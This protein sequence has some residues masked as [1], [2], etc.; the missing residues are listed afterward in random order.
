M[1]IYKGSCHCGKVRFKIEAEIDHVRSCDCSICVKRGALNYR[2]PK[3][4]LDL[5][6]PWDDLILY[7][8]GDK[9]AKD[10][11]CSTCG[12][13]PFRRPSNPTDKELLEGV[14]PFDGWAINARCLEGID[15]ELL[16]V[17]E[18]YGSKI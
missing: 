10:F 9:T 5:F 8:W 18:V 2:V 15:L 14:K 4:N 11:F 16:P 7:Q 6:T 12:I 3:D 13:L 1:R 17:K